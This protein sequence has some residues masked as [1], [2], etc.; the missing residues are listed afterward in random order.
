M[1]TYIHVCGDGVTDL[2][3][4]DKWQRIKA[5]FQKD[6]RYSNKMLDFVCNKYTHL[7]GREKMQEKKNFFSA[8]KR[9][10]V[11]KKERNHE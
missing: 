11:I 10:C 4:H 5:V 6:W 7:S 2:L 8:S 9:D 3:D 1:Y